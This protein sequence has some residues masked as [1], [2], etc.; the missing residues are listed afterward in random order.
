[1]T[2]SV[3][4]GELLE[5]KRSL[6][7]QLLQSCISLLLALELIVELL[8]ITTKTSYQSFSVLANANALVYMD[9]YFFNS[10]SLLAKVFQVF[11]SKC[12][13]TVTFA[14]L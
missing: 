14:A 9:A 5:F 7:D 2:V 3:L 12:D 11:L 4:L 6:M 10:S 1:M 13:R 8:I